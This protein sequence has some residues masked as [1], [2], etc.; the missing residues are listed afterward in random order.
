MPQVFVIF[1][2]PR[3][4]N[5]AL[6]GDAWNAV[7]VVKSWAN[8]E[9][10]DLPYSVR[11]QA[12]AGTSG[13]QG[14]TEAE[15]HALVAQRP[16]RDDIDAQLRAR[17]RPIIGPALLAEIARSY[18]GDG[19]VLCDLELTT[20]NPALVYAA[21]DGSEFH[22]TVDLAAYQ[23]HRH[24]LEDPAFDAMMA[25]RARLGAGDVGGR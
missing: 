2:D 13:T 12:V 22:P 20:R 8:T 14:I 15:L 5:D 25:L 1:G 19:A 6:T 7:P 23:R 4:N 11:G 3:A 24:A 10:R 17:G 16:T 21:P 9:Y 18:A